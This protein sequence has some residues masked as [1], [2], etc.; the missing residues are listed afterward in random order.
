MSVPKGLYSR[1]DPSDRTVVGYE[2]FS[3]A[4]GPV[5]WRYAA[6]VL[7]PDGRTAAG[8]VD[9]TVDDAWRQ[10]RVEVRAEAW[11][12]RGGLVGAEVVWVRA[13]ASG[14]EAAESVAV[15]GG[16]I[17]RSPGFLVAVAR[18]LR[19]ALG[20]T[21]RVRL[22]ALTEPALVARIV[23]T[24]WALTSV[25]EHTTDA[26]PLPV[27]RYETADLATGERA[28]V[29]LAGDVILAASGVELEELD[30]PPS[31]G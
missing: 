29:H 26:G 8:L 19:L 14:E 22:V 12:V 21:S 25:E 6:E 1:R 16:F 11:I 2:R 17:G 10:I 30:S 3:C 13:G 9:I 31:L 18:M 27:E 5:G 24:G 7:A 15:A 23:E 4:R 28:V 20:A